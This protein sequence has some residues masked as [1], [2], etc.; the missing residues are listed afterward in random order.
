MKDKEKIALFI[1]AD[2]APASKIN[3]L[4][5]EL[6]KLGVVNIRR[7]YGNWKRPQLKP[8]EDCLFEHAIQPIHQFDLIKGKNATDIAMVVDIMDALYTQEIDIV[9]IMSSDSDFTP[10][11][12]RLSAAG[13]I[14]IGAGCALTAKSF[15]SCCSA[16]F[17][18][19]SKQAEML[20]QPVIA[21]SYQSLE[22]DSRLISLLVQSVNVAQ[23]GEW[24]AMSD[25]G[26]QMRLRQQNFQSK[27]Y[28]GMTLGQLLEHIGLF[29]FKST[30]KDFVRV[31]QQL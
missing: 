3:F 19:D 5:S 23:I 27:H 8:W 15:V 29:E 4:L 21:P 18:V 31:S 16:F 14:V 1:D 13:K 25:V 11:A 17:Y 30:K 9:C 26:V 24:A 2:N 28:H 12:L 10:L 22:I 20:E 6:N 7:A